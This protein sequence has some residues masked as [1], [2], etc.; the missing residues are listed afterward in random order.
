V[1]SE[2]KVLAQ[3]LTSPLAT[4]RSALAMLLAGDLG[5]LTAKQQE[6][7][8]HVLELDEYMISLINSW[9]DMERLSKGQIV[10]EAEPCNIGSITKSVAGK[11][12]E[13]HR[14]AQWPMVLADPLRLKQIIMNIVAVF[15]KVEIRARTTGDVCILTFHD[16]SHSTPKQRAAI[17]EGLNSDAPTAQLGIRIARLLAEA[18]GGSLKLNPH[19][20]EGIRLHL[21]IP[22]AKQMS[23]LGEAAE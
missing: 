21:K 20:T 9:V 12:I 10:L 3:E 22:L 2:I 6:Y 1:R 11:G 15:T 8:R 17:L 18:H 16:G 7:L 14:N 19:A 5:D 23:L 4:S 13:L